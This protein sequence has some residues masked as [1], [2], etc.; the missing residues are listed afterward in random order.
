MTSI[1]FTK[2]HNED[3]L[4]FTVAL[5]PDGAGLRVSAPHSENR[6]E[7]DLVSERSCTTLT[8]TPDEARAVATEL[9]ACA[10]ARDAVTASQ[11][12]SIWQEA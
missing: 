4:Y 2:S 6:V 9:I 7:L 12:D 11:S 10:D 8:M 5:R 3:A 1:A